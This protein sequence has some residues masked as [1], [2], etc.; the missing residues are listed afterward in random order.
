MTNEG[1]STRVASEAILLLLYAWNLAPIPGTDLP[2]SLVACGRVFQFL[3]DWSVSISKHLEL[4][5]SPK[6][7]ISYAKDQANLL[8]A[9]REGH[10]KKKHSYMLPPYPLELVQFEPVDGP[11]HQFS[12]INHPISKDPFI[13]AVIKGFE[14]LSPSNFLL[15]TRLFIL[16][17]T[18][19]GRLSLNSTTSS[20]LFLGY[21]ANRR[22]SYN[23]L[24]R[25]RMRLHSIIV[26]LLL[27]P[28]P[29]LLLIRILAHWLLPSY[30]AGTNYSFFP[31]SH[32]LGNARYREWQLVCV[33]LDD[34]KLST[35][36]KIP[37]QILCPSFF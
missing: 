9:S 8:E 17:T 26:L 16:P 35:G 24:I 14:P 20:A 15:T 19:T 21:Q 5:S 2:R 6:S 23:F 13:E 22:L 1:N 30:E 12:Q 10:V 37:C 27:L 4:T 18:S 31:N 36:W 3:L 33:A 11:D 29:S 28:L 7:V 34:S 32:S 25:L